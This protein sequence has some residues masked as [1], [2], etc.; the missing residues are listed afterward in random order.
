MSQVQNF[1][2]LLGL[3]RS[4]VIGDVLSL[5]DAI[6]A[7]D[8]AG[9][10]LYSVKIA[11]YF[12]F[13]AD[14]KEIDDIV[15]ELLEGDWGGVLVELADEL[16]L[17][18]ERFRKTPPA[19]SIAVLA[20]PPHIST[21]T[22]AQSQQY[23]ADNRASVR[24][25]AKRP[26]VKFLLR[27]APEALERLEGKPSPAAIDPERLAKIIGVIKFA[28][29][30]LT[31]ASAMVPYLIPVVVVLKLIV[32]WYD[33]NHPATGAVVNGDRGLSLDDF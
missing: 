28:I 4:G 5:I 14:A 3:W 27:K 7:G 22:R 10:R 12:G 2:D 17:I 1:R 31:A 20:A 25:G 21:M 15:A 23:L 33:A 11:T 16:K 19:P 24:E 8:A 18:G 30:I 29:P 9:I 32:A 13:A 26:L 6:K